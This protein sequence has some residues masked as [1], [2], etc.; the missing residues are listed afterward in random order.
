MRLGGVGHEA[1]AHHGVEEVLGEA[2][3]QGLLHD[4][5]DQQLVVGPYRQRGVVTVPVH[6]EGALEPPVRGVQRVRVVRPVRPQSRLAHLPQQFVGA[7]DADVAALDLVVGVGER[8]ADLLR[9]VARHG[10][11]DP[12]AGAEHPDH[13]GEDALVV[14]DVL[15]HLG[16][17]HGVEAVVR[18]GQREGV[19]LHG[20]GLGARRGL[21]RLLHRREPLGD[22][23]DLL[24]VAVERDDARAAPVALEGVAPG[25]ASQVQDPV[26]GG[27]REAGEVHGQHWRSAFLG[28]VRGSS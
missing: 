28:D 12:A 22:L 18:K 4:V 17:D 20:G 26:A 2:G 27:E 3:G 19:S 11:R 15:H 9:A 16:D 8:P 24:A 6:A 1:L 10:H 13:L 23:A 21:P 25:A 7:V 5:P 14:G